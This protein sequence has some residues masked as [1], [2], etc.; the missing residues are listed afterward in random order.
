MVRDLMTQRRMELLGCLPCLG[1]CGI[2]VQLGPQLP[3]DFGDRIQVDGLVRIPFRAIGNGVL[4]ERCARNEDRMADA[5]KRWRSA[6]HTIRTAQ[7]PGEDWRAYIK[8]I[9]H[10]E[11][12]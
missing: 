4:C 7:R 8:R 1:L 6:E 11:P 12:I 5:S 10:E 2:W 9:M 3:I